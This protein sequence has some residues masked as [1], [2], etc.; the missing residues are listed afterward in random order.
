MNNLKIAILD[1]ATLGADIDLSPFSALG[2]TAVYALTAREEVGARIADC[3]VCVILG[4][5]D[6]TDFKKYL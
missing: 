3:D 2:E 4:A 1:A 6:I 5:G